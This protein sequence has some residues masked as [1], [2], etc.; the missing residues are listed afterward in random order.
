M[1]Y[2]HQS[3]SYR[4]FLR[5]LT[6]AENFQASLR[7]DVQKRVEKEARFREKTEN[8][9]WGTWEADKAQLYMDMYD[10]RQL[11]TAST[12]QTNSQGE[13]ANKPV[14]GQSTAK[15]DSLRQPAKARKDMITETK[16][17]IRK[18]LMNQILNHPGQ[19]SNQ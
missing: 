6:S 5:P 12:P 13:Q 15:E 19:P 18:H 7:R 10:M 8:E 9:Q 17:V 14:Q 3:K 11:R 2:N 4:R 16:A 1:I